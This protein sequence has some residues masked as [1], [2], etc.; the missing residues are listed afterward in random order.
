MKAGDWTLRKLGPFYWYPGTI[1]VRA[2]LR[3]QDLL[4][5]VTWGGIN[6]S[7]SIGLHFALVRHGKGPT[8]L[9]T[10]ETAR[11]TLQK[12]VANHR[13]T[14]PPQG[15]AENGRGSL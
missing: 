9:E 15:G 11:D 8:V 14:N 2:V 3:Q 10:L 1:G 7:W 13:L 12:A 6:R 4:V 5:R